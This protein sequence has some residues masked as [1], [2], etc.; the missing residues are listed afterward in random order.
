MG[1]NQSFRG[2]VVATGSGPV[3]SPWIEIQGYTNKVLRT[4]EQRP[5]QR[6]FPEVTAAIEGALAK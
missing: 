3:R 5:G 6:R 4:G 2:I 1:V